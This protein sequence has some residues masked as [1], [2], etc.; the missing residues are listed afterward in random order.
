[1]QRLQP[2]FLNLRVKVS[3]QPVTHHF[4]LVDFR[5]AENFPT[6]LNL[7]GGNCSLPETAPPPSPRRHWTMRDN[8]NWTRKLKITNDTTV[9]TIYVILLAI[10]RCDYT[11]VILSVRVHVWA[12]TR[13]DLNVM[14]LSCDLF[15]SWL[16][17]CP[18]M[19]I[20]YQATGTMICTGS[21]RERSENQ[22]TFDDADITQRLETFIFH[23]SLSGI[24]R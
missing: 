4:I 11:P 19:I 15:L 17:P 12:I 16:H 7:G 22:R 9:A 21:W 18:A 24:S 23:L 14:R 10:P 1:M 3:F 2:W 6:G 20:V 5:Q 8:S 13:H